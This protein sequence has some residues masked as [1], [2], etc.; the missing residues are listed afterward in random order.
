M[1]QKEKP[2]GDHRRSGLFFW[3]YQTGGSHLIYK[4]IMVLL[5]FRLQESGPATI[6][7]KICEGSFKGQ[8][9]CPVVL[10]IFF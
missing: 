10:L 6:V 9:I 2:N 4:H 8:V 7:F 5:P 3:T 1:G